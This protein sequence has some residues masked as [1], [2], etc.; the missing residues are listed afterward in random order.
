MRHTGKRWLSIVPYN[1]HDYNYILQ[2]CPFSPIRPSFGRFG[3]GVAGVGV[4]GGGGS[5]QLAHMSE[6]GSLFA[7][8]LQSSKNL[9]VKYSNLILPVRIF[10]QL[11][12]SFAA[13]EHCVPPSATN[14][15]T[16]P[17]SWVRSLHFCSVA[18]LTPKGGT[19]IL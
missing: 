4:V 19:G 13:V 6:S 1:Y 15:H 5:K 14:L 10:V 8:S 12:T 17:S 3:E 2:G 16:S 9:T 18:R 7:T 11:C